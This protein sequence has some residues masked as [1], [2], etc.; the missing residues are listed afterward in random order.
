MKQMLQS[1]VNQL[2][3]Q[4]SKIRQPVEYFYV[5]VLELIL[6]DYLQ[7]NPDPF[8]VQIGA[9]DGTTADPI[10]NLIQKYHLRGLLVEPQPTIFKQLIQNYQS[11]PQ[12]Q[13]ENSLIAAQDGVA[14]FYAVRDDGNC[15]LPMWC[16]QIASLDRHKML[17]LL[18]DQQQKLNLPSNLESLIQE[19][20]LPALSFET[21]LA[22]HQINQV[23][24]LVIDTMGY[25]FEILKMIPFDSIKPAIINFEHSLLSPEDQAACFEYLAKLGYGLIQVSVDTIAYLNAPVR[26]GLY[27]LR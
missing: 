8:F 1:A 19:M 22:K 13:F 14:T 15:T 11:Q 10:V 3:Y 20:P 9:N 17:T 27:T 23:D 18:A 21:L 7:Q 6:K 16:Y 26:K 4:I 24:L 2:G 12:L 5:D 25:D